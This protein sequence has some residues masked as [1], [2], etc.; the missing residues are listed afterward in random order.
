MGCGVVYA[1]NNDVESLRHAF[2]KAYGIYGITTW[3][4]STFNADGS[5]QRAANLN[6]DVLES[7]EIQQGRNI[8]RVAE[9]VPTLRHFILQS[10]HRGGRERPVKD[11]VAAPLHH[12]AKWAQEDILQRSS[13]ACWSIL[14]QPTY[15][16][17]FDNDDDAAKGTK[18]R[19]L[20][21]GVVSG[22]LDIDV[23]LTVIAVNDL[24]VLASKMFEDR[25][26]Y[27]RRILRAGCARVTGRRL[28]NAASRVNGAAKFRYKPLPWPVLE[29]LIPVEYPKQLKRW[30]T[31][32]GNDEGVVYD[33]VGSDGEG[34]GRE[35]VSAAD[36]FIAE[37]YALHP[38]MLG[39]DAWL[40]TR[41]V[42]EMERPRS[43]VELL[44]EKKK[45]LTFS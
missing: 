40:R 9:T 1:D 45:A 38:G 19:L 14:R 25:A 22:L 26:K 33:A 23:P 36:D 41:G 16:E 13:L 24:G 8:I 15:L 32:G 10:M 37:C 44:K 2:R 21:P 30:L 39:V 12:R 43:V 3:S 5:V 42:A 11:N 4:G 28:T 29:Y 34:E 20:R 31:V 18:L 27:A 6:S 7:S 35:P 17:N